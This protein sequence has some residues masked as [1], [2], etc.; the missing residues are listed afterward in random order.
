M[1]HKVNEEIKSFKDKNNVFFLLS[2]EIGTAGECAIV[3]FSW[4]KHLKSQQSQNGPHRG[5]RKEENLLFRK[6]APVQATQGG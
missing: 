6:A 5:S 1:N 4:T 3:K 2:K